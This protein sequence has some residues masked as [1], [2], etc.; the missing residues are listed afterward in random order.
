MNSDAEQT[1]HICY[2][3]LSNGFNAVRAAVATGYSAHTA[4][5]QG[6]RLLR[7]VEVKDAVDA[8]LKEIESEQICKA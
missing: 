3:Y 1:T 5:S 2:E 6:E 8:R 7:N 4:Y